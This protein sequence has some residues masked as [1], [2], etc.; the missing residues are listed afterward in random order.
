MMQL[1]IQN[2]TEVVGK[3]IKLVCDHKVLLEDIVVSVDS[4]TT[5][6]ICLNLTTGQLYF[7]EK[8]K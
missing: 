1:N 4:K 3:I 8:E 5:N 6:I 7:E 2:S